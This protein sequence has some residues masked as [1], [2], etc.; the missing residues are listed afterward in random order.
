MEVEKPED[1]V[2]MQKE[3]ERLANWKAN[4][5]YKP[6]TDPD[7][8]ITEEMLEEGYGYAPIF[9]NHASLRRF[10]ETDLRFTPQFEQLYRILEEHGRGDNPVATGNIFEC[11]RMYHLDSQ[12]DPEEIVKGSYDHILKRP[13]T[14]AESA[15]P[16]ASLLRKQKV[17]LEILHSSAID[18]G[19][20]HVVHL[21]HPQAIILGGGLSLLWRTFAPC[22]S[23]RSFSISHGNHARAPRLQLAQLEED[24]VTVAALYLAK[25]AARQTP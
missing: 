25:K 5:P 2:E 18:L 12:K 11:L 13:I 9:S 19:L 23:R 1:L 24:A 17:F 14:Y 22:S 3:A 7:V 20:S 15:G 4:F 16:P 6:T 21:Q 10:F 8:V